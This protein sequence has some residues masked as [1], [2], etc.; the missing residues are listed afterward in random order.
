MTIARQLN[1]VLRHVEFDD[2]QNAVTLSQTFATTATDLWEACTTPERL[3]RW[4]EAVEGDLRE[5]G[6]YRMT[7]SGTVGTIEVCDAP[8]T[9]ALTWE[10]DGDVSRVRAEIAEAAPGHVTLT[11]SHTGD[12]ND[13]WRQY[14]PAAGGSGWDAAF[15][16][17][18]MTLADPTVTLDDVMA[19]AAGS[20]GESFIEPIAAAWA[21]AHRA[22]GAPADETEAAAARAVEADRQQQV[23]GN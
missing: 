9:L 7:D 1:E 8:R 10:Y 2:E 14:G 6:R 13:Y 22:A 11:V 4:F 12:N 16:G 19:V 3:A 18:A 5:G 23:S 21:E 17:L 15:L 20:T